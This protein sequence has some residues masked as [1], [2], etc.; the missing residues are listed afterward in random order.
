MLELFQNLTHFKTFYKLLNSFEHVSTLL[1]RFNF[2]KVLK[3]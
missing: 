2:K 3:R 1:N